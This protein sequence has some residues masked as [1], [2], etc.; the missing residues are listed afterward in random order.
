MSGEV[1]FSF[2]KNLESSRHSQYPSFISTVTKKSPDNYIHDFLWDPAQAIQAKRTEV[3]FFF[4]LGSSLSYLG[5][6]PYV[7]I[8][9]DVFIPFVQCLVGHGF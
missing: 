7:D 4:I 2:K 8:F 3:A 6:I 1:V 5:K 9:P